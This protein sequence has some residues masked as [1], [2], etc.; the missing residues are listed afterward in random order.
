MSTLLSAI[1]QCVWPARVRCCSRAHK[2]RQGN[3]PS[4]SDN[5]KSR[6]KAE[7]MPEHGSCVA[8]Q[9]CRTEAPTEES[10]PSTRDRGSLHRLGEERRGT[11][12]ATD[13]AVGHRSNADLGS[14]CG[15]PGVGNN[16][17]HHD[18]L[19]AALACPICK[20]YTFCDDAGD[21]EPT[22]IILSAGLSQGSIPMDTETAKARGGRGQHE[23]L[24]ALRLNHSGRF[25]NSN[26][27]IG[28]IQLPRPACSQVPRMRTES[29]EGGREDPSGGVWLY[30]TTIPT[31]LITHACDLPHPSKS[32][33]IRGV[34]HTPLE[35][36]T[37]TTPATTATVTTIWCLNSQKV[38]C[39]MQMSS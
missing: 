4:L 28:G 37:N 3:A 27:K 8:A 13:S 1:G 11:T 33:T 7:A 9:G 21:P 10:S 18:T 26:K 17:C 22:T 24:S 19:S 6:E 25:L 36:W 14:D 38:D 32:A 16:C 20:F 29:P 35:L 34:L 31:V 39:W 15:E 2:H 5:N 23:V 12:E 30:T